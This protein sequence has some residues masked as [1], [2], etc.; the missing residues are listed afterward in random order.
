MGLAHP[1]LKLEIMET[2]TELFIPPLRLCYQLCLSA[3]LS[4]CLSV[5]RITQKSTDHNFLK[6]Y[7]M[8]EHN[9]GSNRLDFE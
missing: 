1:L 5:N 8:V 7:G 9:L 6:F 4:V 3:C 2:G